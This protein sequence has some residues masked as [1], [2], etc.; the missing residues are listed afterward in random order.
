[1]SKS[2]KLRRGLWAASLLASFAVSGCA[3]NFE[4]YQK[5]APHLTSVQECAIG[6]DLAQQI[7][8]RVSLKNATILAPVRQSGCESHAI[9]YLRQAGF[10]IDGREQKDGFKVAVTE[11]GD[12]EVTAL[13]TVGKG[14]K[15]S[16]RYQLAE[17]GVFPASGVTVL[18]L[19]EGA[20]LK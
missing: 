18:A 8:K 7:Y 11:T 12:F 15:L 1:M 4:T 2:I 20:V 19:P 14:L 16:R 9:N 13:A 5:D 17:T 10:K 3:T 6:Y